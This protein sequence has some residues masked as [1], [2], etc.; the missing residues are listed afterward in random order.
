MAIPFPDKDQRRARD[1][2]ETLICTGDVTT[3]TEL[4]ETTAGA[5]DRDDWLDDPDHWIWDLAVDV[6]EDNAA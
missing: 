3:A 6:L 5:L 4:A 1:C 2:M